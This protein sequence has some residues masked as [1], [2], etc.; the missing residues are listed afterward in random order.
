MKA[1]VIFCFIFAFIQAS[2]LAQTKP[3]G[4]VI[5]QELPSQIRTLY[6]CP[7]GNF[8]MTEDVYPEKSIYQGT[9]S[10]DSTKIAIKL[11][12]HYGQ[13]GVGEQW[14]ANEQK[15]YN[16]Y[17]EF[18]FEIQDTMQV[19][20]AQVLDTNSIFTVVKKNYHCP[21]KLYHPQLPGKYPVASYRLLS[22]EELKKY[23]PEEL[24]LMSKEIRARYGLIFRRDADR[25]YF[26]SQVWYFPENNTVDAYMTNI[27]KRNVRTISAYLRTRN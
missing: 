14:V 12:L 16:K 10:Q 8:Q 11:N 19:N 13:R 27:E 4:I 21:S 9:W 5:T 1:F 26:I 7:N 18:I 23:S 22:K 25:A 15:G 6:F 3:A 20:W 17:K 24:E 2:P